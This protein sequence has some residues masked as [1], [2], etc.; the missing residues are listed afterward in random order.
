MAHKDWCGK[1]C[2]DCETSCGL[3]ESMP[4][5]PDCEN[6]LPDGTPNREDCLRIGCDALCEDD[7]SP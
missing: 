1:P 3:D 5:S 7:D 6:L 2:S 4:C